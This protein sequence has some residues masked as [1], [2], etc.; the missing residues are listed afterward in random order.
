MGRKIEKAVSAEE[1]MARLEADSEY[2]ARMRAKA[3]RRAEHEA[4]CQAAERPVLEALAA[5]GVFVGAIHEYVNTNAPTPAAVVEVLLE[6]LPRVKQHNILEMMV[7]AMAVPEKRFDGRVLTKLFE[8]TQSRYDVRWVI[9]NTIAAARPE[10]ITE[11]VVEAIQKREYGQ[12][13]QMLCDAVV[14]MAGKKRARPILMAVFDDLPIHA[15]SV[16][17]RSA[18]ESLL[19]FFQEKEESLRGQLET[20]QRG[21]IP[22]NVAK[23][24]LKRVEKVIARINRKVEAQKGKE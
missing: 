23:T 2:R 16:L 10:G 15:A 14:K 21:T 8:E 19:D 3:T 13:R 22:H 1:L 7:R 4:E 12:S 18:D 24:A 17:G 6:W 20:L 11:W 9:A 5:R